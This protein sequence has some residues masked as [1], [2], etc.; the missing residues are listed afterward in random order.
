MA[1]SPTLHI[2]HNQCKFN[3]TKRDCFIARVSQH[4]NFDEETDRKIEYE[5][6]ICKLVDHRLHFYVDALVIKN[7][8][9]FVTIVDLQKSIN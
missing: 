3:N 2:D 7:I 5:I 6:V 9:K 4:P 8:K 1:L